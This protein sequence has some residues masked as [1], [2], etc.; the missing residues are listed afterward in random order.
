[1]SYPALCT[2]VGLVLGLV[3]RFFHGPIPQK[4]DVLYIT[5]AVAVWGWYVA[6]CAIG[7]LVGITAW[8]ER[9]WIRGPLCGAIMLVPLSFVSL[10]TPGCGPPCA[11][12]NVGS[13]I[14]IGT[15]VGGI[16]YLVTRRH[17]L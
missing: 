13:A 14:A 12:S 1:L 8:P 3:P 17:H 6:R 11:A 16:A 7:F 2:L 9:W 5:G 15:A 4:Y 10:A